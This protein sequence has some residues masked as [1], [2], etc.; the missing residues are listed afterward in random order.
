MIKLLYKYKDIFVIGIYDFGK[1][2][3]YM[4]KIEIDFNVKFVKMFFYWIIFVYYVEINR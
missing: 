1:C 2:N 3:I 4:Y